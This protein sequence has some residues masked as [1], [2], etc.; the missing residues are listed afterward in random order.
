MSRWFAIPLVLISAIALVQIGVILGSRAPA[1][2]QESQVDVAPEDQARRSDAVDLDR[3]AAIENARTQLGTWAT[4]FRGSPAEELFRF[5]TRAAST[6]E[7]MRVH[8]DLVS[9][10]G[11]LLRL[12]NNPDALARL[13]MA[14]CV[15]PPEIHNLEELNTCLSSALS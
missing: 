2:P 14:A 15:P 4:W 9:E 7:C 11:S 3:E 13:G 1:A 6:S 12:Y 10:A 8:G 5:C